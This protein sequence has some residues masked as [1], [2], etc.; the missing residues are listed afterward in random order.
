MPESFDTMLAELADVA[1]EAIVPPSLA[2]VRRRARQR[3]L[4]RRVAASALALALVGV[5]GGAWAV[6]YHRF[7]TDD[8]LAPM[9]GQTTASS[10]LVGGSPSPVG[11]S[12]TSSASPSVG[13]AAFTGGSDAVVWQAGS[14][15]DGYLM[16]FSDGMV[17]LS[18]TDVF[19]LCYGRL[20]T[21]IAQADSTASPTVG[22]FTDTSSTGSSSA[23]VTV[24]GQPLTDV[25]CSSFG[26]GVA[27]TAA[28]LANGYVSLTMSGNS[29]VAGETL[30]RVSE[31]QGTATN[32]V[33]DTMTM[34]LLSG[35]WISADANKRTL[36]V[37]GNGSISFS[38][39][40]TAGKP[41]TG[42]GMIDTAYP[43][44]ARAVFDCPSGSKKGSPCEVLLIEQ[45]AKS[46]DQI[47]VYGSY[48]AEAFIRKG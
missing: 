15:A 1:A 32:A 25:A 2:E 36:V 30:T 34:K 19:P 38:A 37:G 47:I 13:A 23:G 45:T 17:A 12:G 4:R 46:A 44:G 7:H 14:A 3:M 31:I 27:I 8:T 43:S 41:Y 5:A 39:Y 22:A 18:A 24:S 35:T 33:M 16:I 9:T 42:S 28:P 21:V 10:G 11:A 40:A 48:G 6:A 26:T 20:G 29:T